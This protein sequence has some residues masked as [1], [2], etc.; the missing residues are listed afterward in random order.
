[1]EREVKLQLLITSA[2]ILSDNNIIIIIIMRS[3]DKMADG[4]DSV[5]VDGHRGLCSVCNLSFKVTAGG[6]MWKHGP[7]N[8][9][10]AGSSKKPKLPGEPVLESHGPAPTISCHPSLQAQPQLPFQ[11]IQPM[12]KMLKWIP[13]G[14]RKY[15]AEKLTSSGEQQ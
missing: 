11:P 10:C 15:A 1:M 8:Q 12:V 5:S 14:S 9:R 3:Y 2:Y 4:V 6:L 13:R 7:V